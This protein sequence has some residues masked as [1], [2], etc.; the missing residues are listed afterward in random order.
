MTRAILRAS[1]LHVPFQ[2]LDHQVRTRGPKEIKSHNMKKKK[3][4]TMATARERFTFQ[5]T[6]SS[7]FLSSL[8][9]IL[10]KL[11]F[12]NSGALSGTGKNSQNE[13]ICQTL[14]IPLIAGD[15]SKLSPRNHQ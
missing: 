13:N 5:N 7:R 6:D 2:A 8:L 9:E 12:S 15:H 1:S 3:Q 10:K 14:K 11:L 4:K